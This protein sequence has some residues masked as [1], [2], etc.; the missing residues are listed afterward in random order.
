M[1]QKSRLLERYLK[2][3]LEKVWSEMQALGSKVREP[4]VLEDAREVALETMRRV[5]QDVKALRKRWRGRGYRFGYHW[6][7]SWAKAEVKRSP[8][9][10]GHPMQRAKL[11]LFE[12][13]V[14]PLPLSLW[15]FYQTLGSVNF[16][17]TAP[18]DEPGWPDREELDPLQ[19]KPLKPDVCAKQVELCPEEPLEVVLFPDELVKFFFSGVGAFYTPLP[20]NTADA[21]LWFEGAPLCRKGRD[22]TFVTYLRIAI[23]ER[24]GF[25]LAGQPSPAHAREFAADLELF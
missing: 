25:G 16:I 9:L 4:P 15:A 14:A 19:V 24:G 21:T 1:P 12:K 18:E 11:D 22:F 2:G 23:L 13:K 10:V 5:K 17:G 3:E 7:K 8:P 6:A 20:Q